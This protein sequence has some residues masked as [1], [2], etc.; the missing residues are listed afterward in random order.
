MFLACT[1]SS[2]PGCFH[3]ETY[4][5]VLELQFAN[6]P[7]AKIAIKFVWQLIVDHSDYVP[8]YI[9]NYKVCNNLML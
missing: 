3:V 9:T 6:T 8:I 7:A 1:D 5:H 2:Q 4:M